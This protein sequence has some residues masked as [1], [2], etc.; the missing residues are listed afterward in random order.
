MTL[1]SKTFVQNHYVI[2]QFYYNHA[3]LN[4]L[5]SASAQIYKWVS[6]VKIKDSIIIHMKFTGAQK[7]MVLKIS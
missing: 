3:H 1:K 5:Y 4:I 2:E 6:S 7:L